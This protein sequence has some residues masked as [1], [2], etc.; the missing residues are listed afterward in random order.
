MINKPSI[1][2]V[3]PAYNEEKNIE[4]TVKDVIV[5]IGDN[6]S[7]YEIIIFNDC[8]KDKTGE[9]ADNLALSNS[10]IRVV[11]NEKN[12]GF[13]YNYK[14][15]VELAK[16]DY[17]GIIPGDNE[18]ELESIKN[19]FASAGKADIVI[20]YTA[21]QNIRPIV[22]QIAS[23]SFTFIINFLFFGKWKL[24]Y[25]NGCVLHKKE[26][27]KSV[28]IKADNYAFQAE[29]LVKLIRK[30]HSY[31]QIPMYIRPRIYGKTNIFKIKNILGM[32]KTIGY[33]FKEIYF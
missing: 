17:I 28:S 33:L 3:I 16:N 23:Y 29:A 19:I 20:P 2:V 22:R 14:K 24:N 8:S 9:V 27:I 25:F 1:S 32:F 12:R 18:I 13:A 6:F 26:I 21:N 15:G 30:G 7:T 5:A 10:N 31:I 4:P 11:H